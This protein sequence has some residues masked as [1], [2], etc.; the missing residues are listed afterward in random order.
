V[1]VGC[2]GGGNGGGTHT[3][4]VS[5]T[6][7]R[8]AVVATTQSAQFSATV[9]GD[10]QNRV[11][12]S[13]DGVDGGSAV[14]GTI[15][16]SGLYAPPASAGTHTVRA[17]STADTTKSAAATIAV[18]DLSGVVTYHNNLARD[19]TNTQEYALIPSIVSTATFG[20]LF[21]CQGYG[22]I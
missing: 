3:I 18:T 11:T 13:V 6:P 14:V 9:T 7:K 21:S 19:G 16:G 17:T 1:V 2:G 20:K 5:I 8:A 12:W 10:P 22:P 15:S 4:S